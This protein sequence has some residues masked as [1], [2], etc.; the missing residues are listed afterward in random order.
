MRL[1]QTKAL[2]RSHCINAGGLSSMISQYFFFW[3]VDTNLSHREHLQANKSQAKGSVQEKQFSWEKRA[4]KLIMPGKRENDDESI[5][6]ILHMK[7]PIPQS[8]F[9]GNMPRFKYND[10]SLILSRPLNYGS[11]SDSDCRKTKK[12]VIHIL[13]RLIAHKIHVRMVIII[14]SHQGPTAEIKF[15]TTRE[16]F[17]PCPVIVNLL[18]KRARQIQSESDSSDA[19]QLFNSALDFGA[20]GPL[21]WMHAHAM[22]RAQLSI[23]S[24]N[25]F[26]N[27][28]KRAPS[29]WHTN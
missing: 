3:H 20:W 11:T 14:E 7:R 13:W 27:T 19:P 18:A 28:P 24:S 23:T 29:G 8:G 21:K 17:S 16:F 5:D 15:L 22:R 1:P 26:R 6:Y 4:R 12:R 10:Y 2:I 9:A 25:V